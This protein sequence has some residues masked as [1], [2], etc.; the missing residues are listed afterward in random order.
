MEIRGSFPAPCHL[1]LVHDQKSR[2]WSV[3][4]CQQI[5]SLRW[6]LWLVW[7]AEACW[8][9]FLWALI[10]PSR[11]VG[12]LLACSRRSSNRLQSQ[13]QTAVSVQR[14]YQRTGSSLGISGTPNDSRVF[15]APNTWICCSI[16]WSVQLRSFFLP[17][18]CSLR[19]SPECSGQCTA[20]NVTEVPAIPRPLWTKLG[21]SGSFSC[22]FVCFWEGNASVSTAKQERYQVLINRLLSVEQGCR[23]KLK[24]PY[25]MPQWMNAVFK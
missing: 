6:C 19:K 24:Q 25:T 22:L 5:C 16:W 7:W 10:S 18:Y 17:H 21:E 23:A 4:R 8:R 9:N 20:T 12:L 3:S 1:C 14:L 15:L 13:S 2:L 11:S